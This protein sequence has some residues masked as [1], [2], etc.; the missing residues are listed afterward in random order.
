MLKSRCLLLAA[1]LLFLG[2][3][4]S[5]AGPALAHAAGP[6]N[7]LLVKLEKDGFKRP[8]LQQLFSRSKMRY[9]PAP[10]RGKL[11]ILQK[12]YFGTYRTRRVQQ[13]LAKLG[14]AVGKVDGV[15]GAKTARALKA[16]QKSRGLEVDGVPSDAVFEA[17]AKDLK[18][19]RKKSWSSGVYKAVRSPVRLA[20]AREFVVAYWPVFHAM[21][22]RYGVPW[23]IV[24]GIL[25]VETRVGHFL[26]TRSPLVTL[27]SMAACNDLA[28][29]K[30]FFRKGTLSSEELAWLKKTARVR[31]QW[32]YDELKALLTYCTGNSLDPLNMPGS[33][34]GAFGIGQFMPSSV[35]RFGVDGDKDG[36]VDLFSVPDAVFS[37]GAYLH[38]HGWEGDMSGLEKKRRVLFAYNHSQRYVNSI[39]A[40]ASKMSQAF[41]LPEFKAG[42]QR[43]VR[44]SDV[45]GLLQALSPGTRVLLKPG[46][47]DLN[48]AHGFK[49]QY[50]RC[51][52]NAEGVL[53]VLQGLRNLSI[54]A[55]RGALLTAGGK[56]LSVRIM[57]AQGLLVD[58]LQ[59]E[60][61]A[62]N[63]A[64]LE[65]YESNKAVVSFCRL[66]GG[67]VRCENSKNITMGNT[68]LYSLRGPGVQLVDTQSVRLQNMVIRAVR[69]DKLLVLQKSAGLAVTSS[70]FHDNGESRKTG[71]LFEIIGKGT[72][73]EM[74]DSCLMDNRF[75]LFSSQR[76]VPRTSG[77]YLRGNTFKA[78]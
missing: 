30:T 10:M 27:A 26:G 74:R 3:P 34:Y 78:P 9:D 56:G 36:D 20:E 21:N 29:A 73:S 23:E 53:L 54:Q 5:A 6:W 4:G 12:K 68:L 41:R 61:G 47:Y 70:Y 28:C 32:A 60:S 59:L 52:R 46:K 77:N 13:A 40:V 65:F 66:Q 11:R 33:I 44:V 48:S 76:G 1:L 75:A 18:Q 71:A 42:S 63:A 39:L 35:L 58:G 25:A 64:L 45:G 31:S 62:E 51:G 55:E 2:G 14:Y 17:L 38:G 57:K 49:S 67:G 37:V 24:A 72:G 69:T 22:Q 8:T 19:P 16:Y 7:D 43:T 50:V 15:Y